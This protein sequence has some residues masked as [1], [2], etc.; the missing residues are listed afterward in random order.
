MK[1]IQYDK[2]KLKLM[3]NLPRS[4]PF[5]MDS[6][7]Y[8]LLVECRRKYFYRIVLGR[9]SPFQ[10]FAVILEF[11]KHYHKFR[12]LLET[13]SYLEAMNYILKVNLPPQDPKSKFAF[14]DNLR[15]VKTCQ[16]AYESYQ[17][18]KKLNK[19]QVIAVEQPF[20]I[21]V[22]PG[23]FI[24]GRADQIV[25][26]NGR[27][28]GRDFKTT[29]KDKATFTRQIDPNDQAMRYI[30]GE[31][32]IHGQEIQGIIFEAVYNAKTVGPTIY[33][34]LSTRNEYQKRTWIEE[35]KLA[36]IQLSYYRENDIWPMDTCGKCDWC[37]YHKVCLS[38]SMHSQ[39]AI[40]KQDYKMQIW[41]HTSV[42][43]EGE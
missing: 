8:K 3:P 1:T 19:I 18:E 28:W 14:L 15:L 38:G 43:Q 33:S 22:A 24:G 37:E 39:E 2:D 13:A 42:D 30:I 32:A 23:L 21:E 16:T 4:E 31:S 36:A 29:T 7:A 35:Q 5:V 17:A 10:K 6:T 41:D 9:V 25:K 20:N 27:L 34:V 40:L 12:E 26:W 11:G